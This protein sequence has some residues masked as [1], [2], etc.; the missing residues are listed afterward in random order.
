[1][2]GQTSITLRSP[3][4]AANYHVVRNL[5]SSLRYCATAHAAMIGGAA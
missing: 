1:M 2:T 3:N 5:E 4:L